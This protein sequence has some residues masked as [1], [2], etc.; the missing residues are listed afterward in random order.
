MTAAIMTIDVSPVRWRHEYKHQISHGEDLVLSQRLRTLFPR[1]AHA[2]PDGCYR[3]TSL[4]FDTP[5]DTA[6]REKLDGADRREKFRLRYYGSDTGL[7]RLEKKSKAH[8]LCAKRS[9]VLTHAQAKAL[10]SGDISFLLRDGRALCAE[11]YAKM[12][13]DGLRPKAIVQYDRE[14]FVFAPG[15]VRLTIDRG[16]RTGL[17]RLDFLNAGLLCA[18]AL[19]TAVLE[20]KYDEFLPDIV[21]MAVQT[22]GLR[23]SACSKYAACR[24]FD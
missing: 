21:R 13:G 19:D 24:R 4:Y 17:G 7:I 20:V 11:L 16:V 9:A 8:G 15:N 18:R 23:A 10:L 3:V 14:A 22:H 2:G 1:D 5:Y 6:L 12:R